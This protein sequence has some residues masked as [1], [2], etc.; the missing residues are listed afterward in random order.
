MK[1]KESNTI[2][3]EPKELLNPSSKVTNCCKSLWVKYSFPKAYMTR[4]A[5]DQPVAAMSR[6]PDHNSPSEPK[7]N[8]ISQNRHQEEIIHKLAVQLKNIGDSI[9]HRIVPEDLR[10]EGRDALAHFA[11]VL[12]GGAHAL[13]RFLRNHRLM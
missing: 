2:V 4:L 5:S 3:C 7:E 9:N 1:K 6:N 13:L 12:F 10:W 11:L 8:S